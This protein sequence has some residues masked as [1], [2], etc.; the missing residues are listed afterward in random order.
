MGLC[1]SKAEALCSD[2][3]P[4]PVTNQSPFVTTTTLQCKGWEECYRWMEQQWRLL[5]ES[6]GHV[7]IQC[8]WRVGRGYVEGLCEGGDSG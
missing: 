1:D 3:S 5:G 4:L 6:G 7:L 2:I 8:S